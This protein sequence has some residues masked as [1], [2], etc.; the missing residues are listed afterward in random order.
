MTRERPGR[1]RQA[2]D[3][4][5]PEWEALDLVPNEPYP[6]M[7]A[8]R[9]KVYGVNY[10]RDLF[11]PRQLLCHGTSVEVFRELF[12]QEQN[13][14]GFSDATK[15]AFGYLA[16]AL[17]KFLNWNAILSS[18][19]VNAARMRSVFDRHDFAFKW[20]FAEMAP[21][22][23]GLGYEW[24]IE[25]TSK[26]IAELIDLARPDVQAKKSRKGQQQGKLLLS[27]NY[28]PPSVTVTCKSADSLDHLKDQ[29]VDVVVMDPPYYNNVMYAEL[30]D[31][32][33]VWLKRTAGHVYPEYFRRPLTDKENEAVANP[34][35]FKGS[36]GAG[37]LADLDYRDRMEAIF[38]ECR[39]VLKH[40]GIM[41]LMFTHK[42]TGAWDALTK[43]L[44]EA[45]FI[46]TASWPINT[47]AEGSLHIKDKSAANSTIFLVCRP[48]PELSDEDEV[49]FWEDLE[50]RVR[51]AVRSRI[52]DFQTA[53][54]R[55]VDLYLSSFGPALEEYSRHWPI[56]RGQPRQQPVNGKGKASADDFGPYA[57]SPED[58]LDA[59]RREV[60]NWRIE[61]LT[62]V[63]RQVELDPLTEWFVLAWDAFKAPRFP[64]DEALRLARVVG[65]DMDR[66]VI[67]TIA[68]KKSSDVILWDSENR[69]AKGS[70]GATDGSRAML[71]ALHHAA[72]IARTQTV[73]GSRE[74]LI[75]ACVEQ[76]PVFFKALS[77]VLEVLPPSE[78]YLGF[79]PADAVL[80]AAGDF[81]ALEKLRRLAFTE[82]VTRPR[83]LTLWE[84]GGK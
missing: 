79:A 17:D 64:Y 57:A 71:D 16:L 43:G 70:L 31:F 48:R 83:Q 76:N 23:S 49:L 80:P 10:W 84:G 11:S 13:K 37:A 3:E 61:Q 6:H 40:D 15:A 27:E 81:E 7:F 75:K 34:A 47:E 63:Q 78:A 14:H 62:D 29:S 60:K 19:N 66:E 74:M 26:C 41:T 18:W 20:S 55:G 69:A 24:V 82:R 68:E 58:A 8:D 5:L 77:A 50:P 65:L 53:G 67:G 35:K 4:K 21:L 25:A 52:Q 45:G 56:R 59:A 22:I 46:I 1:I 30:S 54:I 33:Y 36:K 2:L 12:D 73:G 39:R 42:A 72:Y 32:F 44:M 9:S 38:A 28:A 51:S